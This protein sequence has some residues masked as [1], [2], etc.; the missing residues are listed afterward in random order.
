MPL[1]PRDIRQELTGAGF[2]LDG[3]TLN[4]YLRVLVADSDGLVINQSPYYQVD[5]AAAI[6]LVKL[7]YIRKVILFQF[8]EQSYRLFQLVL[9]NSHLEQKQL[10]DMALVGSFK[11]TKQLLNYMLRG[12]FLA[13]RE[14]PKQGNREPSNCLYLWTCNLP[15][16]CTM[17]QQR[18][19]KTKANLSVRWNG[20]HQKYLETKR[21]VDQIPADLDEDPEAEEA[22]LKRAK[23]H[24]DE[25]VALQR[26]L[27]RL[28]HAKLE[29]DTQF[30]IFRDFE[31]S[32]M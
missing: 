15:A 6:R 19:F 8:G 30:L 28:E 10:K 20:V 14:V 5:L 12:Q 7:T 9:Q 4:E 18:C 24:R 23:E 21:K 22:D 17:M 1:T 25:M 2:G 13:L 27:D 16:I 11:E 26:T 29:I 3:E 32:S 31:A